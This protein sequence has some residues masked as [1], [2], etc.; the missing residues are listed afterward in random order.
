MPGITNDNPFQSPAVKWPRRASFRYPKTLWLAQACGLMLVTFML[1]D[2]YTFPWPDTPYPR[3]MFW[4]AM[5]TLLATV[6][7]AIPNEKAAMFPLL[8]F[9]ICG[10]WQSTFCCAALVFGSDGK[11][12]FFFSSFLLSIAVL[13]TMLQKPSQ[14]YYAR[15]R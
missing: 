9:M 12:Y 7:L 4:L 1:I 2:S 13:I 3:D 14:A 8:H 6:T 5:V 15:R 11:G 10:F